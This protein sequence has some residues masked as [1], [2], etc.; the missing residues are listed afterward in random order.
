MRAADNT[1]EF[2]KQWIAGT[3]TKRQYQNYYIVK[4]PHA[5][6]LMKQT[7][8]RD[9]LAIRDNSGHIYLFD[10]DLGIVDYGE[11]RLRE[12]D[13]LSNPFLCLIH[14][15][16]D[17]K[18][19][20]INPLSIDRSSRGISLVD[21]I[22]KWK[23]LDRVEVDNP[24]LPVPVYVSLVEIGD[25]RCLI[26]PYFEKDDRVPPKT[27]LEL[28]AQ[29]GV[30]ATY[31]F[32]HRWLYYNLSE[33]YSNKINSI[34]EIK[35][36]YLAV[37]GEK[38]SL[39]WVNADGWVFIPTDFETVEEITGRPFRE[40]KRARPNPYA[41][42]MTGSNIN[43]NNVHR[44]Y[45]TVE[46]N[47]EALK[48]CINLRDDFDSSN[49]QQVIKGKYLPETAE[50]YIAFF[51]AD[52]AWLREHYEIARAGA[53]EAK[54]RAKVSMSLGN[55]VIFVN[56]EPNPSPMGEHVVYLKANSVSPFKFLKVLPTPSS[57]SKVR[58]IFDGDN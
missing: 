35:G 48:H 30:E 21:S 13:A 44:R 56:N 20:R 40:A 16:Y 37:A 5:Q 26:S 34:K 49:W 25:I 38:A 58:G 22:S 55:T 18:F 4:T 46:E 51:E 9:L 27:S 24:S 32:P 12:N 1:V 33:L 19:T 3:Y 6:F 31:K 45:E 8:A 14:E 42:G 7:E 52:D 23:V 57:A 43:M 41:Y 15:D 39:S 54:F 2:V 47:A 50:D 53:L 28:W 29:N 36:N 11:P 10:N 17:F